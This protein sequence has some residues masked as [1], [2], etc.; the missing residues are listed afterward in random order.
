MVITAWGLY[1]EAGIVRSSRVVEFAL[2]LHD[3]SGIVSNPERRQWV[4]SGCVASR[5]IPPTLPLPCLRD[6][7]MCVVQRQEQAG[8]G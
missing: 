2:A 7:S 8:P 1:E 4:E 6:L 5:Q 3:H